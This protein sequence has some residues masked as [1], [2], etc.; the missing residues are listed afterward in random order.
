MLDQHLLGGLSD[1]DAERFLANVPIGDPAIR[2]AIISASQGLPYYLDLAV[3]QY[4]AIMERG[5]APSKDGFG[6]RPAEVT[7]RFLSHLGEDERRD[8]VM[9]SYAGALDESLF[10]TLLERFYGGKA[11]GDWARLK[12]RSVMEPDR[13]GRLRM[14][15]L[16]QET[17]QERERVDRPE[18]F[19]EIHAF[20]FDHFDRAAT[21][22]ELQGNRPRP[23]TRAAFSR[24]AQLRFRGR[25]EQMGGQPDQSLSR[26]RAILL[27]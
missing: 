23:G 27:A 17:L 19:H 16:M 11:V 7:E 26:C 4:S 8:L 3:D 5:E 13:D 24:A 6:T 14:H 22:T 25:V 10:N 20:L 15:G 21:V 12:R 2:S 1:S 18:L 9:V